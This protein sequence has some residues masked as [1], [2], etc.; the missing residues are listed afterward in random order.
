VLLRLLVIATLTCGCTAFDES[1]LDPPD[2]GPGCELSRP[3]S[4][5]DESTEGPDVEPRFYGIRDPRLNQSM[6][7]W[8]TT[9]YDLDDLCSVPP[10]PDQDP[11]VEC[12][13]P[14]LSAPLEQDGAGGVDNAI[15]HNVLPIILT[16][17]DDFR[18]RASGGQTQGLGAI[19][20]RVE[21]WNGRAN[22]PRVHAVFMQSVFGSHERLMEPLGEIDVSDG[23]L[24]I[25]GVAYQI[26]Q[27]E[28]DDWFYANSAGFL[29][30]DIDRP[31][32]IDDNAYI[33]D[34]TLVMRLPD[35]FPFYL[36]GDETGIN[37]ALTDVEFTVRFTE[38][39]TRIAEAILAGRW[40]LLDIL[41]GVEVTGI[42]PDSDDYETFNRLLD[43]TADIRSTPGTGGAGVTC[44]A[45]SVGLAFDDGALA[46]LAGIRPG[47]TL[48]D[49][50]NAAMM[51]GGMGDGGSPDGG[52]DS[53]TSDGGVMDADA[54]AG[55]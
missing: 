29:E 37:V 20:L 33:R 45:I 32:L 5:P 16:V 23:M 19:L 22:D 52:V 3:P 30:G 55:G 35:R 13:A 8:R 39:H 9:G 14:S 18:D 17:R 11:P 7:V 50:C 2:A 31:R 38:D 44:D 42:C 12:H 53:S 21:Q 43:L 1:L 49:P 51:D 40:S 47:F 41:D 24:R 4:R 6:D 26:P 28:G 54:G 15:G 46:N 27:W 10:E 25:D 48:P 36:G 34:D